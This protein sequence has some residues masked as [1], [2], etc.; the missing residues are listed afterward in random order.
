VPRRLGARPHQRQPALKAAH[1]I[2]LLFGL[3]GGVA[4]GLVGAPLL[5]LAGAALG[6]AL[7]GNFEGAAAMGGAELGAL[8]GLLLGFAVGL[9]LVMR[10]GGRHA[11]T[12]LAFMW[13]GVLIVG[14]CVAFVAFS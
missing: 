14:G 2:R 7:Y 8:A 6:S 11:G 3:L 12:A 10:D 1:L 13:V 5:A 4:G 9:W